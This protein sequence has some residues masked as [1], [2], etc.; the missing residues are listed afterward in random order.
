MNKILF[1]WIILFFTPIVIKAAPGD[2]TIV[3]TLDFSDITKRR[4]WYVFPEYTGNWHKILMS[5]TLKCDPATTQDGYA[6]GEWDYTTYTNLYEYRNTDALYYFIPGRTFDSLTYSNQPTFSAF[7]KIIHSSEINAL[8][9]SY[10]IGNGSVTSNN[11][12]PQ[13]NHCSKSSFVWQASELSAAGITDTILGISLFTNNPG[14]EQTITIRLANKTSFFNGSNLD[15]N[16]ILCYHDNHNFSLSGEQNFAF[17]QPF[18]WDGVSDIIVEIST[19]NASDN[20]NFLS[21]SISFS[22]AYTINFEDQYLAFSS[23]DYVEVP[24]E[25]FSE[26]DSAI[27]ISFWQYGD[28]NIQPSNSYIFEGR[29]EDDNRVVNAHLPWG[30]GNVYWDAGNSGTASYDRIYQAANFEDYAGRWNHWAFTKNVETGEMHIYLNGNLWLSGTGKN[31]TMSGITAFKIAGKANAYGAYNGGINEFRIWNTELDNTT[32]KNWMYKKIDPSHTQYSHLKA[33]YTFDEEGTLALNETNTNHGS[34]VG[35]PKRK[36]V[37]AENLYMGMDSLS[38]RPQIAFITDAD[39]SNTETIQ[40]DT[41]YDAALSLMISQ[42]EIDFNQQGLSYI[43]QDTTYIW[44]HSWSYTFDTALTAID[45]VLNTNDGTYLNNLINLTHQI[46]NYVTPYGINLDLGPD[47]FTWI[48]DVTDYAPILRDTVEISAGNQQELIDLKF[49]FIEGTPPRDVVDFQTIWLGD[50]GHANIADD[51]SLPAVDVQL[52]DE[53]SMYTIRTRTTG[54]WFGEGEN[55]AEFCPKYHNLKINGVQ[56]FE[57]LNWKEC[58]N[59]PVFPQGGTWIYDRAGWCPG[60]FADTYNHDITP[61]VESGETVSIDYGMEAYP[62][63]GGEGNY[64]ITVQ[65][66]SYGDPNFTNDAAIE[67]IISPNNWEY[68]NRYNPNA[69]RPKVIIK[70]TGSEEL[71]TLDFQYGVNGNLDYEYH[72]TGALSFLETDTVDLYPIEIDA[73]AGDNQK[74]EVSVSNPNGNTDEYPYNNSAVSYFDLPERF[75]SLFVM[76]FRTNHQPQENSYKIF[77]EWGSIVMERTSDELEA[78]HLYHDTIDLPSGCYELFLYDSDD[79]GLSF[80]ANSDG[81][82]YVYFRRPESSVLVY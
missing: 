42:P 17:Y 57:W 48:Y 7:Q 78:D 21:D 76:Y 52:N 40:T 36:A 81:N 2:T 56:Q 5:Y 34:L 49:Y 77:D 41:V 82:G 63:N 58:S 69:G 19:E 27:T 32:I 25:V 39:I 60:T 73:A 23:N 37:K 53:A 33:Y 11:I 62:S 9:Q 28:A 65:L 80:W 15:E 43:I 61:F 38:I 75:D 10:T 24:S 64:R 31:K 70:N 66:I 4:G 72:W 54:H 44:E 46:Q 22:G 8:N 30:N 47:G 67:D 51:V 26:I 55:C 35:L 45:S 6:C 68:Y 79:D 1:V 59:N 50:W 14:S 12:F 18:V 74:F 20:I 3:Q 71:S 16:M 29:D 13:S